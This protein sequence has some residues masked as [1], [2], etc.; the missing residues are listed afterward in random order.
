MPFLPVRMLPK[1]SAV[2]VSAI[3]A[4]GSV[5]AAF[6][7][8][9]WTIHAQPTTR[10]LAKLSFV[11]DQQG[12]VVGEIG[13]ILLTTD[14]GVTWAN[15]PSPVAHDLVDIDMLDKL[16]GF[17]L[18]HET[19]PEPRDLKTH[20]LQTSNGGAEWT[21]R[22]T[23]NH[24]YNAAAYT[25]EENGVLV[26]E[27]GR[28]LRTVDGARSWNPANIERPDLAPWTIGEVQFL[29]ATFG[30]AMGGRYDVTGVVWRTQDGGANWT[31]MRVAGEPVWGAFAFDA[32][33]IICV[34]GDLDYGAGMVMTGEAG[35]S[36]DYTDLH[37]WGQAQAVD[38]RDGMEGWAP[39]GVAGAY[40]VSEDGGRNWTSLPA[41]N[42]AEMFDV[43]FTSPDVGYMVGSAGTV[44]RYTPGGGTTGVDELPAAR[45]AEMI[46]F[47]NT[48]NPFSQKTEVA[49]RVA[50]KGH[51]TLKVYDLAGREVATLVNEKL[52]PGN[53]ARTFE[54]GKLAS[55]SYYYKLT[56][57]DREATRKMMVVK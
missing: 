16:N 41:P 19:A 12:W 18:A 48:P 7:H 46:L 11:N 39:L 15:Q 4:V 25:D 49:F 22:A 57:G 3:L 30:L 40:M 33:N 28:I 1:L 36:W 2:A 56:M 27:E 23:L 54:S 37:M 45:S 51:V 43:V 29:S 6:A 42:G 53:Y 21:V 35:E 14:G 8:G 10:D 34:G 26:G 55:G 13:T 50:A 47:Q 44:L 52:E 38:F 17:A 9:S 20:V 31:H 32:D 5:S 24:K